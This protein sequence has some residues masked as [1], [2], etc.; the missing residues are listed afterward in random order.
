MLSLLSK[1]FS[2]SSRSRGPGWREEKRTA[3]IFSRLLYLAMRRPHRIE[4]D[5]NEGEGEKEEEEGENDE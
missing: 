2:L 3:S 1:N 4:I 5:T